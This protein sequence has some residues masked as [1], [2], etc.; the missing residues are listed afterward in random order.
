MSIIAMLKVKLE[1]F[2]AI[3]AT[4]GLGF[5]LMM[6]PVC[7]APRITWSS[8]ESDNST[9][10]FEAVAQVESGRNPD[11]VNEKEDAVGY[12][13]LRKIAVDDVNRIVG[14]HRFTYADRYSVEKS[15]EM[16]DVYTAYWGA[17]YHRKTGNAVTP[18]IIARIYNGGPNGYKKES[19]VKYWNLVKSA[20]D[21]Q[22]KQ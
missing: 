11:K 5:F 10:L 14:Q 6:L 19:T 3:T 17:V 4:Q 1:V 15:R 16:F 2:C 12:A 9:R 8:A 22:E 13:Q 18:E 21:A 7:A 20:L